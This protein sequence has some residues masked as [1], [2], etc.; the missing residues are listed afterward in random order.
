MPQRHTRF[1]PSILG[2]SDLA[3]LDR[4]I[5]SVV[6]ACDRQADAPDPDSIA[7]IVLRLYR[8]GLTQ[9]EKLAALSARLACAA[10]ISGSGADRFARRAAVPSPSRR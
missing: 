5:R 8:M 3:I 2:P 7:R 1:Y 9:P 10:A 6:F 4:A